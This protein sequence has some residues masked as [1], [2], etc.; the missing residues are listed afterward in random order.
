MSQ[1]LN[2]FYNDVHTREEVVAYIHAFI[3]Q[4]ALKRVYAKEDV[5]AVADARSLI[6]SAF[7]NLENEYGIR[8]KAPV[9]KNQAR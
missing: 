9:N 5:S 7:S 6:D 1:E 8:N 4:E 3:D 2:Q